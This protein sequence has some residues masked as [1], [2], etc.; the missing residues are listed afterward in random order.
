MS[1][2]FNVTLVEDL[3]IRLEFPCRIEYPAPEA[4][5]CRKDLAGR[6]FSLGRCW[7]SDVRKQDGYTNRY[8]VFKVYSKS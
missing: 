7:V 3:S 1:V 8:F 2:V 4:K 5:N 6:T